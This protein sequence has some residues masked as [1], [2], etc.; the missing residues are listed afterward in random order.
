V[1]PAAGSGA[2]SGRDRWKVAFATLV[3]IAAALLIVARGVA[4]RSVERRSLIHRDHA[5][6]TPADFG[7]P[8][9]AFRIAS[10]TRSLDAVAVPGPADT[11][12]LVVVF[13]GTAE[14]VSDWADVQA[15]WRRLGVASVVFDYSGFGR[16]TG[17]MRVRHA[18]EDARA[19]WTAAR[20]RFPQSH[21]VTALGYSLGAGILLDA[22]D[23]LQPAPDGVIVASGYSS[24]REGAM[25]LL[26]L[27][28]WYGALLPDLWNNVRAVQGLRSPLL[29]LHST[30]D[31]LFAPW[32]PEAVVDA[33]T[34]PRSLVFVRGY[35]HEDGHVRPDSAYWGAA[36]AFARSGVLPPPRPADQARASGRTL[37]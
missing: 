25:Q 9:D 4:F 18:A 36:M 11:S 2:T 10:G 3:A 7:A 13:H 30:D 17:A 33:A 20:A 27:P 37:P 5:G 14:A 31:Q 22:Y 21:R 24:A 34:V 1:A 12:A 8:F 6:E 28:S 16:S 29:V 23:A 15:I 35:R 32:M 19:A 26:D